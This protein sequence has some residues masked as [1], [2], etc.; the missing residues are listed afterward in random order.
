MRIKGVGGS[1]DFEKLDKWLTSPKAMA[2]GTK[3]T[4][5]GL[6]DPMDRANVIAYL[7]TQGSNLPLPKPAAAAPAAGA[8]GAAAPAGGAAAPQAGEAP[9]TAAQKTEPLPVAGSSPKV[10]DNKAVGSV[11][12]GH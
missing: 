3:M 12:E 4:F 7:N 11:S 2:P 6:D 1:W 8:S 5:A 10:G 9:Q